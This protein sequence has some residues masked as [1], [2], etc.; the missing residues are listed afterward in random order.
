[1]TFLTPVPWDTKA[2]C[3]NC[4]EVSP[5]ELD[6]LEELRKIPGHFTLR[7]NPLMS[8]DQIQQFGFK[9]VD[10]LIVPA[11][12]R[13]DFVAYSNSQVS[14]AKSINLSDVSSLASNAFMHGR[15]HRD[16]SIPRHL[17]EKRYQNWLNDLYVADK[18]VGIEYQGRLAAFIAIE[19]SKLILHAVHS[20]L[21]GHG[22]AKYLWTPVC[23]DLFEKGQTTIESSIS[24]ANLAVVN[25]Y[26]RL[27]FTIQSAQDIYHLHNY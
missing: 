19:G 22:L 2:F 6:H 7:L 17:A 5:L 14:I 25:L 27:G 10:T 24:A 18:V 11:C 23:E 9:Y 3:F 12:H 16:Y 15:Y 4:Y 21:R 8:A 26:A 13:D 1:M 20:E